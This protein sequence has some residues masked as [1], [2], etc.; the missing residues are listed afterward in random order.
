VVVGSRIPSGARVLTD[1]AADRTLVREGSL[2]AILKELAE[3]HDVMHVL[4][5]GGGTLAAA[6]V[7]AGWVDAYAFFVAPKLMGADGLP[8]FAQT[9]GLVGNTTNLKFTSVEQIGED[10]L[11]HAK[12]ES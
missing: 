3:R 10:L 2:P 4:C 5:E 1:E 12:P 9:G 6:L 11:I 7:K 8:S